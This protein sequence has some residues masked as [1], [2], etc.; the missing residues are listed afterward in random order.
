MYSGFAIAIAWPE[1]WCKQPGAWYDKP[2][3]WLG[4]NKEYYYQLGH[5]ALVL[6]DARSGKTLYFDFG[7]YHAP[8]GYGRVRSEFTDH[9]LSMNVS[10]IIDKQ[11][12]RVQNIQAILDYLTNKPA[13]HGSGRG[14]ASAVRVNFDLAMSEILA[15]QKRFYKYG[16]FTYGGSNCSRFVNDV[17]V[18]GKP[19]IL[20]RLAL[21][22]P[23]TLTPTTLW[24]TRVTGT[25]TYISQ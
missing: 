7:R 24:N 5:A 6:V 15:M 11:N 21:K 25:K 8:H 16:P 12:N 13:C 1:T 23:I 17:M 9:E 4:F 2:M 20:S 18:K 22:C 10:A 14:Y 19:P 3:T